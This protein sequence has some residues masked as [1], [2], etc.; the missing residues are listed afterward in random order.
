M[1]SRISN[2][3]FYQWTRF[4]WWNKLDLYLVQLIWTTNTNSEF[5]LLFFCL[6][7]FWVLNQVKVCNKYQNA[8]KNA[9]KT[10]YV[11][12]IKESLP[13]KNTQKVKKQK[14][15][16]QDWGFVLVFRMSWTRHCSN[17]LKYSW[18]LRIGNWWNH[19]CSEQLIT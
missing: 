18:K 19:I 3:D 17:W 12:D 16:S 8:Q 7:T 9:N 4:H 15:S 5:Q 2:F 13:G 1:V 14:I 6:F 10:N 11:K